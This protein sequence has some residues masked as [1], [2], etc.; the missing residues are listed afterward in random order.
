MNKVFFFTDVHGMWD[1]YKA[2][3][4][5]CLQEDPNCTIVYGGDACDRGPD[6]YRIIKD[7]L[8]RPNVY[9]LQ[10]NHEDLF[11][12]AARKLLHNEMFNMMDDD[13]I[14]LH[15]YNGGL[16]TL[17]DWIKD[18]KPADIINKL[19]NLPIMCSFSN[20]DF[21]HAGGNPRVFERLQSLPQGVEADSEDIDHLLWDRNCLGIGWFPN[22]ICVFGHT[23][24]SYLPTKYCTKDEHGREYRP[25]K[26]CGNLNEKM[27]GFKIDMD[28]CACFSGFAYVLDC[29]T[30]KAQGFLDKNPGDE[31]IPQH[32]I[33]KIEVI[34]L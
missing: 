25:M 13:D 30:M 31:Q 16:S 27:T 11:V 6:G 1:L 20:I 34:Q 19:T 24:V 15:A 17:N 7:L 4:D 26:F 32:S 21:C 2:M 18:G 10:G 3:I 9:Y 29:T 14:A 5:Y 33:E 8:A 23:P 22:R 12:R 28:T